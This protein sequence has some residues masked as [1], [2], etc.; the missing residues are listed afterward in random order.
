MSINDFPGLSK[1]KETIP[2]P[3]NPQSKIL[4]RATSQSLNS[5]QNFCKYLLADY[6]L[7]H[8]KGYIPAVPDDLR[9]DLDQL[10]KKSTQSPMFDFPGE[11]DPPPIIVPLIVIEFK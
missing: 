11:C 3:F 8:L 9:T 2:P 7:G 1:K 6:H 4:R 10:R 5:E